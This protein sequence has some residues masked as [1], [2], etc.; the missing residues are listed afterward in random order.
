MRWHYCLGHL[1][2]PKLKQLALNSKIPK[3]LAKVLPPKCAS[4]LFGAMTKLPWQGKETKEVFVVTKPGEC[5]LVNQMTS[6]EV[7]FYVQLRG[8]LTKKHYKCATVFVDHYGRLQ[9]VHLPLN[10]ESAKTLAAKLPFK[11]YAAEHGV[12][13][14][15]YH[16][17]NG[18]FH[19]KAFRQACHDARQQLIFCGVNTH[20]QNGIIKQ[21]IQDLLENTH[22][23]LLHARARWPEVVHF[24]LW[25]YAL[26][27][28]AYLHNNLPVLEDGTSRL[29]FFSSIQVGSNLKHVHTLGCPV[30]AL[31]NALASGNQLPCWSA[32]ARLG[33]NLGPSPMHTR[34]VYLILNLVTGCVSP[35][36]H[37]C[38]D[39]FFETTRHSAPVVSGTICWQQLANLDCAKMTLSEVSTPKQY[40][41]ISSE[42]PS[43]EESHTMSKPV[44]KPNTYDIT[45]DD[46]SVSDAALQVSENSCTSRQNQHSHTTEEV[47]L[48]E[49]TVTAGTSYEFTQ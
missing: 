33:L 26:R 13:I 16:C 4:C 19:N 18:R 2:F 41:V 21:A 25:P 10:N 24:T 36:Y 12:K 14:L 3:K 48:V 15:H 20:F 49:P 1:S 9:F 5:I 7:G 38:F 45:S 32:R 29:E 34:N 44:F 30:F 28:A 6:T 27:N 47:T 40:S 46:Y 42:T 17:D 11:Q 39:N 23:Q 43:D 22:T 37:C 31:Q 35:Q 8:K